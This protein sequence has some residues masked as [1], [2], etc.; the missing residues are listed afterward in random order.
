MK[1]TKLQYQ[2]SRF[3]KQDLLEGLNHIDSEVMVYTEKFKSEPFESINDGKRI[4]LPKEIFNGFNSLS[5]KNRNFNFHVISPKKK[6]PSGAIIFLHGL[7]ERTWDKYLAWGISLVK[8]TNK[9]VIFFPISYHMERAP[10]AWHDPRQMQSYVSARLKQLPHINQ[11]SIANIALSKRLTQQP[12]QFFLS[13][14]ESATEIIKLVDLIKEGH[15]SS[16]P[17]NSRIDF[18]GYS[19]GA[20]LS[21]VLLL[22]KPNKTIENARYFFLC[23][24]CAFDNYKPESKYILDSEA[25]KMLH[26]F[27]KKELKHELKKKSLFSDLLESTRLGY[28]FKT[29]LSY[30]KLKKQIAFDKWCDKKQIKIIGLK[31]DQVVPYK[32]LKNLMSSRLVEIMDFDYKYSHENPFPVFYNDSDKKVDIAFEKVFNQAASFYCS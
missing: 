15:Y 14:F 32:S 7:N 2:L 22:A 16:I 20:F 3:H 11:L 6:V 12:E 28:A 31:N 4:W 10:Q 29:M 24:G 9:Q 13:G 8:K 27:Y 5:Y 26:Q 19:I 21:E 1:Y 18:F 25:N 23:G 17:K 30:K